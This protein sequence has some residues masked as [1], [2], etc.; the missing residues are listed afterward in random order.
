MK[1]TQQINAA[2]RRESVA[3]ALAAIDE[4]QWDIPYSGAT[5][6]DRIEEANASLF[7]NTNYSEALTGF[8]LG[9]PRDE[10]LR[11]ALELISPMVPAGR[12]F[13]YYAH[14]KADTLEADT[15]DE[16]P[17]GAD[18]K[19][20]RF[21]GTMV[22]DKLANRGLTVT[23]DEDE[24]GHLTNWDQIYTQRL[25]DRIDRNA[26]IRNVAMLSTAATNVA[27][28]WDTTAGKDPDQDIL[29]DL[30]SSADAGG[31]RGNRVVYAETAWTKRALAHRAQNTAGG[32]ASA[33]LSEA[34]VA[35]FLGVDEVGVLRSR[36][37]AGT[38]FSQIG[39]GLVLT[40]FALGGQMPEDASNIKRFVGMIEGGEYRVYKYRV[41]AK[42]WKITVERYER[43]RITSLAGIRKSTIS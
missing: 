7:D 29:T 34:Q 18:F 28:T 31:L 30:I 36:V 14:N 5:V 2:K 32:F 13:E 10:G 42:L 19:E 37:T 6:H 26:L 12:R 25:L 4:Q 3:N 1:R 21:K 15:D 20:V 11:P 8:A 22:Q 38:G 33:G 41:G 27:R 23:V 17:V 9:I 35:A 40:F 16:R 39:A 24:V 43:S